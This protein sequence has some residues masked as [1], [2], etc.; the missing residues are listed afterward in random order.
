MELANR[1]PTRRRQIERLRRALGRQTGGQWPRGSQGNSLLSH[2]AKV[3]QRRRPGALAITLGDQA[4]TAHVPLVEFWPP[5]AQRPLAALS[6]SADS[7][8]KPGLP[9]SA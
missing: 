9:E 6:A 2:A 3:A 4:K 5:P 1:L 8:I 7:G